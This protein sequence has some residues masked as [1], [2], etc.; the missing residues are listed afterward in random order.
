MSSGTRLI[1]ALIGNERISS[2]SRGIVSRTNPSDGSPLPDS[3]VCGVEEVDY[4]VQVGQRVFDH[5][6]WS[7]LEPAERGAALLRLADLVQRDGD[8]LAAM[9]SAE[10]GKP[11]RE[12]LE[13]DVGAALEALRWFAGAADKL[14]GSTSMTGPSALGFTL[15][16]PM[17]VVAAIMP[18]NYPMAQ[19]AWKIGPALAAGNSIILKPSESTPSSALRI[20]ELALEAGIPEGVLSVLPGSGSVTGKAM[21]EH[22]GISALSFTGSTQI[23][24]TI[25]RASAE[26]N[27]KRI[28][29]E[30]G[31]K[32]PQILMDDALRYDDALFDHM[33]DA[34]FL[35]MGENCTA[36]SRILAHES[37]IDEVVERFVARARRLVVG[38]ASDPET[39]IGPLISPEAAARAHALVDRAIAD[40]GE[41]AYGGEKTQVADSQ[42]V[43]PTVIRGVKP[44][45]EIQQVE[46]FGPVVTV[47]SF[48]TE[49]EAIHLANNTE[50][51]LAASLW[52]ND[53]DRV[54][55]VAR[56]LQAGV[57]SVNCYSEGGMSTPFGGYK[58]S[59]FGAKERGMEA[60]DQW[61]N[62]KTV[63][64]QVH[65]NS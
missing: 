3:V 39:D 60:F 41:L 21:A 31:G 62:T 52:T 51:G 40:G 45:S 26:S 29:L 61:T 55:R 46:V 15:R 59:G 56:A 6:A 48:A 13:G 23:G 53:V 20:A 58:T 18:W 24:R 65:G 11:I 34:A 47:A 16:E 4:A 2:T 22:H 49:A 8:L 42:Y 35:T 5:G 63:W 38:P 32:S 50:Y 9:D 37:I 43:N 36:G 1:T 44:E 57:V 33:I 12:C 54:V 30:T 28:A 14:H 19:A 64:L 25:L 10:A 27:L 17:G 7:R